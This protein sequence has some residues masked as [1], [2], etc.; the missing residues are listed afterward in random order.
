MEKKG[1]G[2]YSLRLP[3]FL[4]YETPFHGSISASSCFLAAGLGSVG[5]PLLVSGR[6]LVAVYEDSAVG[7]WALRFLEIEVARDLVTI[8][9]KSL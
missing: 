7:T 8:S 4:N 6:L 3:R 5:P 2:R 1:L 9:L